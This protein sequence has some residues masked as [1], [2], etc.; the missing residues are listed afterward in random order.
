MDT[1]KAAD[2]ESIFLRSKFG[3][4]LVKRLINFGKSA[5]VFHA[6]HPDGYPCALKVF[7][8]ELIQRYGEEIQLDRIK[9]EI[10]LKEHSI[11]NLVR[12]LDGG[13]SDVEG[14][15]Y[16]YIVMEYIEGLN[17]K[18]FYE[19]KSYDVE[20]IRQ[21]LKVLIGVTDALMT[22]YQIA[23]RDI[24]PENVMVREN[25]EI[26]LMDLG[27]IRILTSESFTDLEKK[28]FIGTL[29][30]A[31]P[32]FLLRDEQDTVEGWRA[33]NLYQIGGVLHDLIM[34]K[35]LFSDISP[36]AK[37]VEAVLY[38]IP[39]ISH[40][41][42]PFQLIQLTRDL[43]G[44]DWKNRLKVCIP[45]KIA[46]VYNPPAE[47]HTLKA[48][49]DQVFKQAD[50]TTLLFNEVEALKRSE[51]KKVEIRKTFNSQLMVVIGLAFKLLQDQ[52]IFTRH[53]SEALVFPVN[54]ELAGHRSLYPSATYQDPRPVDQIETSI[55]YRLE[56]PV[57]LGYIR[58]LFMLV[59]LRNDDLQ[60]CTISVAGILPDLGTN[61]SNSNTLFASI[62]NEHSRST[63]H[64]VNQSTFAFS[65]AELFGGTPALD[66][67]FAGHI[68]HQVL[69]ILTPA[70]RR[71]LPEANKHIENQRQNIASQK[72][73]VSFRTFAPGKTVI[74]NQP[75]L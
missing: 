66:Q 51:A 37:Q 30:Y 59:R 61:T 33:V 21:A 9:K 47:N 15:I 20:F 27:V 56:G 10:S 73:G 50:E 18:E 43:L 63:V 31:S 1:L 12:I 74:V 4:Y 49:V 8:N 38:T 75:D 54:R 36:Y 32:E 11:P 46:A 45:Q 70:L 71:M 52:G 35:G 58:P 23:H 3:P 44:K 16:H 65:M 25:G 72:V 29:L 55:L 39:E 24:K 6:I 26:V 68:A 14:I 5:A 13:Q 34:R 62:A 69:T 64:T 17:I 28:E 22:Q 60:Y 67:A 57:H 41:D 53:T 48:R 40:S 42:Y 7:D 2:L 19:K